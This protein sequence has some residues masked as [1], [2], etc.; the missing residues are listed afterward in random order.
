M[1]RGRRRVPLLNTRFHESTPVFSPD[2]NWWA[3]TSDESGRP[4]VYVQSFLSGD[5]PTLFGPRYLV[6]RAGAWR[7]GGRRRVG[8]VYLGFDGQVYAV[9]VTL[10]PKP[11]F[12]V[13]TPLFAISTEARAAI[14]AQP[15][16][17]VSADGRR[18]LI[19]VVSLPALRVLWSFR[20]GKVYYRTRRP[21][22]TAN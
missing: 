6:S 1:A 12:G 21:I 15:G 20:T 9:P 17:D 13:A 4:E 3:F 16:F 18:F 5:Q 19:P 7:F 22:R 8:V 11:V 14:H 10:R 2:G